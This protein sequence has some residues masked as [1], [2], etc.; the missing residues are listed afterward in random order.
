MWTW[1]RSVYFALKKAEVYSTDLSVKMLEATNEL[2]K[3]FNVNLET[4]QS[5]AE[6]IK[7]SEDIKFDIIYCGNLLHHVNIEETIL[8]IKK[9]LKKDGIFVSWDPYCINDV[10][11]EDSI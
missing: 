6:E 5:S 4:F 1:R 8:R 3:K 10:S 9:F 7:I 2:A 11:T